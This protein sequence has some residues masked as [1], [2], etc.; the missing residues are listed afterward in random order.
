MKDLYIASLILNDKEILRKLERHELKEIPEYW[1]IKVLISKLTEHFMEENV[2]DIVGSVAA[3]CQSYE[4]NFEEKYLKTTV[5]QFIN[6]KQNSKYKNLRLGD[7]QEPLKIYK[8]EVDAIQKVDSLQARRLAFGI[9][10]LFKIDEY[11]VRN[12]SINTMRYLDYEPNC[13]IRY[14]KITDRQGLWHEL[15]QAGIITVPLVER[16]I[17][18][19]I[20]SH[21][22]DEDTVVYEII[23]GFECSREHYNKI[24][25]TR[26][27]KIVLEVKVLD[28]THE[29]HYGMDSINQ[30]RKERN[31]KKVDLNNIRRVLG[32]QRMTVQDSY[33]IEINEEIA[34][35]MSK[36]DKLKDKIRQTAK[37][38]RRLVKDLG[39]DGIKA[40]FEKFK[41]SL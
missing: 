8:S 32:F 36:I 31:E 34:N 17:Y 1:S 23:D 30:K 19:N 41:D 11:K 9:L 25:K 22:N 15:N 4:I 14:A 21:G 13:Y 39:V 10:M 20:L 37:I 29:I 12:T 3:V 35:D 38:Y 26:E 27:T 28:N 2:N 16:G 33:W 5:E 24:F 7:I 6:K 18:C 40:D